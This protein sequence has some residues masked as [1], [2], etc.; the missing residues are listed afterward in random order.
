MNPFI[1]LFQ[2]SSS[3]DLEEMI[4]DWIEENSQVV[5]DKIEITQS[6]KLR[7]SGMSVSH[8]S[9][10]THYLCK[11]EYIGRRIKKVKLTKD[12]LVDKLK[13]WN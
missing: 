8:V 12:E 4:N 11:I 2:S 5:I 9:S 10:D 7:S 1:K 13:D 6:Q 3:N